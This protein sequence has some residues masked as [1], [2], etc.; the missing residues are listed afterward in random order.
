MDIGGFDPV[1]LFTVDPRSGVIQTAA[2]LDHERLPRAQ[3]R[4]VATDRGEP[5]NI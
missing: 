4:V 1:K 2:S 3:L 5:V